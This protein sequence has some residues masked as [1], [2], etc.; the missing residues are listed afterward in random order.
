M[1]LS[2]PLRRL[3]GLA[4]A[5][6]GSMGAQKKSSAF[7]QPGRARPDI[8]SRISPQRLELTHI[9]AESHAGRERAAGKTQFR[10]NKSRPPATK[11]SARRRKF[12]SQDRASLKSSLY[13][14]LMRLL[15]RL[16]QKAGRVVPP[17]Q[18]SP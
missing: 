2:R 13:D 17:I 18:Q 15:P 6:Y 1:R 5:L 11:L 12:R 4:S 9:L 10:T 8:M 7:P 14:S 16:H 3:S